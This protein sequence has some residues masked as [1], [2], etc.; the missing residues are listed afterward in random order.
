MMLQ[1]CKQARFVLIFVHIPG[2]SVVPIKA[3]ECSDYP[4]VRIMRQRCEGSEFMDKG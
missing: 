2:S 4:A 1:G 3:Y